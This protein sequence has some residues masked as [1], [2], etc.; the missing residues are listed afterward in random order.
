MKLD[1][2]NRLQGR[3]ITFSMKE[4]PTGIGSVP[5]GPIVRG[6]FCYTDL[7]SRQL[8]NENSQIVK[9]NKG[10]EIS[11][12]VVTVPS[13]LNNLCFVVYWPGSFIRLT[14]RCQ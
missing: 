2:I 5:R 3:E 10:R 11:P 13:Y 8:E 6:L 1:S 14:L 7:A 9:K 4:V 12:Y